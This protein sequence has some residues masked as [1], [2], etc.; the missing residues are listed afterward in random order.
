[1][2]SGYRCACGS[3]VGLDVGLVAQ[4]LNVV[5]SRLVL[6]L[7]HELLLE[8]RADVVELR[9]L[10]IVPALSLGLSGDGLV[11]GVLDLFVRGLVI[12]EVLDQLLDAHLLLHVVAELI[13]AD[14]LLVSELV[15]SSTE[16]RPLFSAVCSSCSS[17][18]SSEA[19]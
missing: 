12:V 10:G 14:A 17:T 16:E 8:L 6:A 4:L 7:V 15:N 1:M 5:L 19:S 18:S 3:E 9:G 11:I 2:R 13:L